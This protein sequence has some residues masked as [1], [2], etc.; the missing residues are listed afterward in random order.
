MRLALF[1]K[2]AINPAYEAARFGAGRAAEALVAEL[3]NF[4][5]APGDDAQVQGAL[6]DEALGLHPRPD[7]FVISPLPGR[8]VD[9]AIR[10][11]AAAGVPLF[12]F[13]NPVDAAPMV[14]YVGSDDYALGLA[15]ARKLFMHLGAQAGADPRARVLMLTGPE[16]SH[17]SVERLR[18]FR[19]A[20][21]GCPG[22]V[23][24][25]VLAGDYARDVARQRV[26]RWLQ[27]HAAPDAVLAAN[28]MMA[29][30]ALDALDAAGAR[31]VT[32][33][34]N[35][36]PEAVEAIAAGRLLASADFN[37]MQ[38]AYL[39]IECAV[40]HLRGGAVPARIDLPVQLV[41]AG[42]CA[43]WQLPYARRPLFTLD[44]LRTPA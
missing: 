2:N 27:D 22:V 21:A 15:L 4:V 13:V 42:N 7:A 29:L 6:L 36:I 32:V 5:P 8:E 38:M 33:G 25:G 43:Q 26:A 30:G 34:V 10:R 35:A 17:T 3:L 44:D 31:A 20:A 18:G 41:H 16:A 9:A 28:D 19:E 37:A 24:A 14:G 39:A 1:T 40:R 23:W 12:G 11:V